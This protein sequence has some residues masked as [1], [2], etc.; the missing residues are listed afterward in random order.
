[1]GTKANSDAARD[2]SVRDALRRAGCRYTK[3]RAE[4]LAYLEQVTDHPTAEDIYQA[5]RQSMPNISLATVYKALEALV[6]SKL[7]TKLNYGD[8]SARYDCRGEDHYHLRDTRTGE[9]RD[10]PAEFDP[11]LLEKLDAT[12]VKKLAATGFHVT[13]YRLEVLGEYE[14]AE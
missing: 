3:Q 8:A 1:M 13:G 4:V 6:A 14:D 5:V 12:L 9:V 7:A 10:L 2:Q 11:H